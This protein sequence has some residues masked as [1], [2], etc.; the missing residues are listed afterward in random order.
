MILVVNA[1][2]VG[3]TETL[4]SWCGACHRSMTFTAARQ[5]RRASA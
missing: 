2:I 3:A 5:G 4:V 1:Q